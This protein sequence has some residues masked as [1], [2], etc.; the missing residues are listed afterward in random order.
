M[1]VSNS[2][3]NKAFVVSRKV[4]LTGLTSSNAAKIESEFNETIGVDSFCL[5][6]E[7]MYMK[8]S[9]DASLTDMDSLL[10]TLGIYN[11]FPY[12]GWWT[13]Y[14]LKWDRQVD[15]NIKNNVKHQPHCCNKPPQGK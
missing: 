3:I 14:K 10:K 5:R 1:T 2:G 6:I 13:R 11:V 8:V 12:S 4:K 9:Y 7:S 15:L